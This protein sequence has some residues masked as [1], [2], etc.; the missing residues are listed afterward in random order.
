[1]REAT[2]VLFLRNQPGHVHDCPQHAHDLR[3]FCDVVSSA[4]VVDG[5]C[6][7][8]WCTSEP[9]AVAEPK[10][11]VPPTT[12]KEGDAMTPADLE[13]LANLAARV[14]ADSEW[15]GCRLV[16]EVWH[17]T[18]TGPIAW[19]ECHP[20]DSD[21][22]IR[23]QPNAPTAGDAPVVGPWERVEGGDRG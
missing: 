1:M 6:T 13:N 9:I 19:I 11:L 2:E 4:P 3:E 5:E 15:A 23:F 18:D 7:A 21:P 14:R 22:D 10:P 12:T 20:D 17:A 16:I 8:E